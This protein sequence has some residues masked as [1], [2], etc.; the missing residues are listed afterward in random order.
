[1]RLYELASSLVMRRVVMSPMRDGFARGAVGGKG[2]TVGWRQRPPIH[3]P[4][5]ARYQR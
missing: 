1:M 4:V 3:P 2:L 5:W